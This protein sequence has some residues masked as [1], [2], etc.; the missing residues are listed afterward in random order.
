M[1]IVSKKGVLALLIAAA[2]TIT[3]FLLKPDTLPADPYDPSIGMSFYFRGI[4]LQ[5]K[6]HPQGVELITDIKNQQ[7]FIVTKSTVLEFQQGS[8]KEG[9]ISPATLDDLKPNQKIK[10]K[11]LRRQYRKEWNVELVTILQ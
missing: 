5:T 8:T 1:K 3:V 10:I 2:I 4:L 7:K 6:S 11:L 9:K